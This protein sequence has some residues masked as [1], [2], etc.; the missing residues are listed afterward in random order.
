MPK[1]ASI[2]C[3]NPI[4][5][6]ISMSGS[7]VVHIRGVLAGLAR[8]LCVVVM[9]NEYVT[10]STSEYFRIYFEKNVFFRSL[11][12]KVRFEACPHALIMRPEAL[13]YS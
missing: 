4:S 3:C 1:E 2:F 5:R 7:R 12:K 11:Y 8:P 13:M 10:K 6:T 9:T